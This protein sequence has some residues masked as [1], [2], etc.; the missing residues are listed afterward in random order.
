MKE[1]KLGKYLTLE[2]FCTCTQTY[3]KYADKINPFPENLAETLP[4]IDALTQFILEPIIDYFGVEKF[5]LTYGFC[6]KDLKKYLAKKDPETGLKNGRVAPEIDQHIAHEIN[7]NGKYY[8][9]RLGA[10]CDF[11]IW[12]EESDR[13]ID[14]I[15]AQKLP[16]DSLY[17]Y[18]SERPIHISYGPQNKREIWTFTASGQPTKK[19]IEHWII[20]NKK[21]LL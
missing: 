2:E 13:V 9:Q 12:G 20:L 8:C 15:L 6:S 16:F 19:G 11:L 10:A 7:K 18:G 17:F 3:Q 5:R 21:A 14:W 4:A 1:V